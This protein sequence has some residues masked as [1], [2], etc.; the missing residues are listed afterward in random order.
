MCS[1]NEILLRTFISLL[2]L[3][4]GNFGYGFLHSECITLSDRHLKCESDCCLQSECCNL[5]DLSEEAILDLSGCCEVHESKDVISE[6]AVKP[7]N[8]SDKI[9]KSRLQSVIYD[10]AF[11]FLLR[12]TEKIS[13]SNTPLYISVSSLRI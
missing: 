5:S 10:T 1:V 12:Y 11:P 3:V 6:N 4:S 7:L 13:S 2:I 8:F 9:S